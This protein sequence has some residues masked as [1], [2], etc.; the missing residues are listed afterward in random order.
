M[1][2]IG[3]RRRNGLR[4][5][6]LRRIGQGQI[7]QGRIGLRRIGPGRIGLG[8]IG[9]GRIGPGRIGLGRIGLGARLGRLRRE[10]RGAVAT[11]VAVLLAGG[12]LLGM[13]AL[14]ID[15]GQI[16]AERAELQNGADA[17]ALAVASGCAKGTA[18]CD[19][20]TTGTAASYANKNAKDAA[21]AVS[22]V[23]GNNGA[24]KLPGCPAS[25]GAMTACPA[26][27]AAGTTYV[28]VHT[29]T[30]TAGGSTLL[31]PVFARTLA[32]NGGYSGTTVLACARARWGS[33]QSATSLAVTMSYCEWNAA[34]AN[35]TSYAAPPP[36]PPNP[37]PP[38]SEDRSLELHGSGSACG[39]GASGWDLP[40]GFGWLDDVN[41]N[42]TAFVDVNNVYHDDTGVSAGTTCKTVLQNARN[43]RTVVYFP[44]YDGAGGTGHSGYYH[45]KGFAAFV[46]TGYALPGFSA[47]SWLTGKDYCKG[48]KKCVYGYFTQGLIPST[49]ALGGLSMG[50]SVV[51]LAG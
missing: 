45:L 37:L 30:R 24:A 12:V 46:V 19:P 3:H 49:G 25:T 44:V 28:D 50:A 33:P 7:G 17:A 1:S 43:N 2:G 48:S 51:Q 4:R 13:G 6:G 26:T 10:D 47:P 27:P 11:I 9:P 5:G 35:G 29:S 41:G 22:L 42:C 31:P 15:V 34:T 18:S 20:S 32:G 21:S 39:G 14:V 38:A 23:C 40:S 16:Y 8:R 36:Y